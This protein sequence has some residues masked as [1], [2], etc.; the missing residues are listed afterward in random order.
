MMKKKPNNSEHLVKSKIIVKDQL[1]LSE[2]EKFSLI[3]VNIQWD[4]EI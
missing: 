2:I 3:L 1:I 4:Q